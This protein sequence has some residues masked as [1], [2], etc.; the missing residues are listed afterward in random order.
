MNR[1]R[2]LLGSLCAPG[3]MLS[4]V[5]GSGLWAGLDLAAKNNVFNMVWIMAQQCITFAQVPGHRDLI[6]K[7]SF[8][9]L[10][11]RHLL[12]G[13]VASCN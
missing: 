3:L 5:S 13:F 6:L 4:S 2:F 10:K 9:E 8:D 12:D 1:R 7:I 11:F